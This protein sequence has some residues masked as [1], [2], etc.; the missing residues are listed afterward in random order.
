MPYQSIM[1]LTFLWYVNTLG[2]PPWN[3]QW[4]MSQPNKVFDCILEEYKT[5]K[6]GNNTLYLTVIQTLYRLWE[7]KGHVSYLGTH[8]TIDKHSE[9]ITNLKPL[10]GEGWRTNLCTSDALYTF[11]LK[12]QLTQLLSHE[13]ISLLLASSH[14]SP[15][16]TAW[17][18]SR[19][20]LTSL[21]YVALRPKFFFQTFSVTRFLCR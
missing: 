9:W 14:T 6:P 20:V 4:W 3:T 17:L 5:M 12:N 1:S 18:I 11:I 16:S 13:F 8:Q 2:V 7:S 19:Q 21:R 15:A 10:L